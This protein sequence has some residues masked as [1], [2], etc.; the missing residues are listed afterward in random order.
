M[1][2]SSDAVRAEAAATARDF[3]LLD[4]AGLK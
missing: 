3:K 4:P 2:I 1:V